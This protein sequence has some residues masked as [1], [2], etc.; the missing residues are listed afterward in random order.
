MSDSFFH[1][2]RTK[3]FRSSKAIYEIQPFRCLVLFRGNQDY[4]I[5]MRR[6]RVQHRDFIASLPGYHSTL[7]IE[8][9]RKIMRWLSLW[10]FLRFTI[11]PIL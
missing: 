4:V 7:V 8:A 10:I 2:H 5:S 11:I 6:L 1:L 3:I 9:T